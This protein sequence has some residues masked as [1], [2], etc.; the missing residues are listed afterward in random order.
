MIIIIIIIAIFTE[1]ERFDA[2]Y[3]AINEDEILLGLARQ[4][5]L[6]HLKYDILNVEVEI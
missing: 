6:K 3:I 2:A 5:L 1:D 4:R